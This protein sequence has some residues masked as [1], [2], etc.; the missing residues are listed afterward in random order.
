MSFSELASQSFKVY[1]CWFL[2][3][4]LDPSR[5]QRLFEDHEKH[6]YLGVLYRTPTKPRYA[7]SMIFSQELFAIS[8]ANAFKILSFSPDFRAQIFR[9]F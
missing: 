6:L 9:N 7:Q 2:S 1:S 4:L 3:R 8:L 5:L